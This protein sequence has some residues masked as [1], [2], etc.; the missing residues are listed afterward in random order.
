LKAII[1]RLKGTK[2]LIL[3][4]HDKGMASMLAMGFDAVMYSSSLVVA[5]QRVTMSHCPLVGIKREDTTGMRGSQLGEN[6]HGEFRHGSKFSLPDFGQFHL[7]GHIHSPNG[8][9]SVRVLDKQY[10][11]GVDA[12]NYRPVNISC[13]ESWIARYGR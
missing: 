4:N 12:N 2:I 10:D 9:R 11:V 8:G 3:G 6:W 1:N 5:K 7:H 13:I